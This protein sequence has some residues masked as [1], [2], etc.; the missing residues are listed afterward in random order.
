MSNDAKSSE[1]KTL[2]AWNSLRSEVQTKGLLLP[3]PLWS[4]FWLMDPLVFLVTGWLTLAAG[5][6][7]CGAFLL[8]IST[9]RFGFVMHLCGHN[10]LFHRFRHNTMAGYLYMNF[11]NG[12][13]FK[14]WNERHSRHHRHTNVRT[15]DPDLKT[16]PALVYNLALPTAIVTQHQRLMM[17]FYLSIYC[18][19]WRVAS[20]TKSVKRGWGVDLG[21][22]ALHWATFCLLA[23]CCGC[24]PWQT[25]K[26]HLLSDAVG[27]VYLGLV[28]MLN[29]FI[30]D[31]VDETGHIFE[32]TCRT[33]RNI[34]GGPISCWVTGGLCY[35][36]E[37]HLFPQAP[38]Q[39]LAAIRLLA[40]K[41]YAQCGLEYRESSV[42]EASRMIWERL[43]E[44]ELIAMK[45]HPS[46]SE[47]VTTLLLSDVGL[48][49][50]HQ[51]CDM[52]C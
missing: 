17:P 51:F 36:I 28:F 11:F 13:P 14:W 48:G 26:L 25:F 40:R 20:I 7:Y 22:T 47:A 3:H 29:H 24:S 31:V 32:H 52:I 49:N 43:A 42:S 9:A 12:V 21:L 45:Q 41:K 46:P 44:M 27:G 30:E 39:N 10:N 37:H 35:Q 38:P 33:T 15:T 2:A 1:D 34:I 16:H 23:F 6:Y 8:G 5:Y 19:L 50:M 18:M 4:A